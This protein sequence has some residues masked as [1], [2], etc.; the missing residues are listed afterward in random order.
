MIPFK[1]KI[2]EKP[3]TVLLPDMIFNLQQVLKFN[4]CLSS[5]S[6]KTNLVTNFLNP[7]NQSFENV[8]I[9]TFT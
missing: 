4:I 5:S 6:S 2:T 9:V 8:S 1:I 3:Q 7:E